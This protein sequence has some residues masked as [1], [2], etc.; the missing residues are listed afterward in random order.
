MGERM[1]EAMRMLMPDD[2]KVPDRRVKPRVGGRRQ[3]DFPR[4]ASIDGTVPADHGV[5]ITMSEAARQR[6]MQAMVLRRQT[7][8][9][10]GPLW[11]LLCAMADALASG[12]SHE[13][14][15]TRVR[16]C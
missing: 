13:R 15:E 11:N 6:F 16:P 7:G 8:A 3:T 4:P 9:D 10:H 5:V 14:G 1:D 2:R 12:G